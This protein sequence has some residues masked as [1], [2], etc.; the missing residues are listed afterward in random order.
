MAPFTL[1]VEPVSYTVCTVTNQVTG[2][3]A[4]TNKPALPRSFG[5]L[6][7]RLNRL[8]LADLGKAERVAK[9]QRRPD[10]GRPEGTKPAGNPKAT[11]H[12]PRRLRLLQP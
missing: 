10:P 11:A 5:S 9:A 4:P 2:T 1:R 7:A 3:A 8:M 12:A 6:V